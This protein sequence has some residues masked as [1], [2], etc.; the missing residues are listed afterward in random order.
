ME[1]KWNIF[2]LYN[3]PF[4]LACLTSVIKERCARWRLWL[5]SSKKL[6]FLSVLQQKISLSRNL[7]IKVITLA[8]RA[9][10]KAESYQTITTSF[11]I[12]CFRLALKGRNKGL[13]FSLVWISVVFYF[14]NKKKMM[15]RELRSV[16]CV[17]ILFCSFLIKS[18]YDKCQKKNSKNGYVLT[19]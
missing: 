5:W 9:A 1:L 19:K 6:D 12:F 11:H 10:Y 18:L 3:I 17:M 13:V 7:R 2:W 4:L 14:Q 8:L 16:G 15:D